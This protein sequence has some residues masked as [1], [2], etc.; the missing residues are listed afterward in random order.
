MDEVPRHLR[1][2]PKYYSVC[3]GTLVSMSSE[4][5][6]EVPMCANGQTLL[7]FLENILINSLLQE[8]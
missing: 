3:A 8:C 1:L 5:E 2:L 6:A 7:V 4:A